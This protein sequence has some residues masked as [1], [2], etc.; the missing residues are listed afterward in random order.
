MKRKDEEGKVVDRFW[1]TLTHPTCKDENDN[2]TPQGHVLVS[3]EILPKQDFEEL[4]NGHGRDAPN[5][6][7]TLPE[8]TGR[9][10]FVRH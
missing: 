6:Y 7:P 8:P 2:Y 10:K 3:V 1:L 9:M 4:D 5:V